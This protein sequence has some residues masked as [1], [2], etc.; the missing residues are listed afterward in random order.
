L[1]LVQEIKESLVKRK[2]AMFKEFLKALEGNNII[3]PIS[4][5][6]LE[7][8]EEAEFRVKTG[9][10]IDDVIGGGVPEGK[11]LLLYGEFGSG[12]TQTCF[13]SAVLCPNKVIYI[14]TE[15][16]FRMSR[17]KQICK[18]RELNLDEVKKKIIYFRPKNWAEQM[19]VLFSLPSPADSIDGKVDLIICDSLSKHFRGIE[20]L[21]RENLGIKNGLIREF[22]LTLERVAEMHNAAF[23]YTTQIY[24]R[25][26]GFSP[27]AG[28]SQTQA[29]VGGRSVE[30][31]PDIVLHFRKGSGNIRVARM[32]D[33]SWNPL[34][35]RSFVINEKGIDIIPETAKAYGTEMER[36]KK[37]GRTQEK[38]DI[39]SRKKKDEKSEDGGHV[40]DSQNGG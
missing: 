18:E 11:S 39:K 5:D 4:L 29:A 14:D 9:T 1:E 2:E 34:G 28:P 33:S 15:G 30:H 32:M 31:Q 10:L 40:D 17:I 35:E 6:I 16:S 25:V 38:E 8:K 19:L 3:E 7:Q 37:F 22:V 24:D 27:K 23:I 20:F 13:T 21:G 26:S 12:K 36:A